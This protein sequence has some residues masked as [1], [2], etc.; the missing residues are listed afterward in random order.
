MTLEEAKKEILKNQS[1]PITYSNMDYESGWEEAISKV[2]KIIELV[3]TEPATKDKMTLTE[4]AHELR[5]IFRFK[6]LAYGEEFRWGQVH[7][8]LLIGDEPFHLEVIDEGGE[9]CPCII[10]E[11]FSDGLGYLFDAT[12][13]LVPNLDL[14]EYKDENGEIDFSKCIVEVT[15]V[16][17]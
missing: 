14:S 12:A 4:L 15:N 11:W 2:L 5:K 8:Q 7:Y 6:Y 9:G 17:E 13:Y 16:S 3:D 10:H 1:S